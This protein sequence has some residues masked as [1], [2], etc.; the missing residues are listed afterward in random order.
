MGQTTA[1]ATA[2]RK[3]E[4]WQCVWILC[5]FS[6]VLP[7]SFVKPNF[8]SLE[9][10]SGMVVRGCVFRNR[11][12]SDSAGQIH[13]GQSVKA[14]VAEA[15]ETQGR[16]VGTISKLCAVE[17]VRWGLA[18]LPGISDVARPPATFWD[19]LLGYWILCFS[20][21]GKNA[22]RALTFLY[23]YPVLDCLPRSVVLNPH[24]AP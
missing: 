16:S 20:G 2:F 7:L 1:A 15:I 12:D 4:L 13:Q 17:S 11:R 5:A 14:E 3:V 22:R 9:M 21:S 24:T 10:T 18:P 19:K 6:F 8:P 23:A